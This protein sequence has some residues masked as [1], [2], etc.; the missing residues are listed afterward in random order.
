LFN[1]SGE[2]VGINSQ[3]YS[4]SGGYMGL[5]FAIPIDMA[6][7]VSQQL[8]E[9]G[10]VTRGKIGVGIRGVD[11]DLA[12]AFG[13]DRPRGALVDEVFE[14]DPA[15]KAGVRPG[16]IVLS[17]DGKPVE[18]NTALPALISSIRPGN[19]TELELWS[20]RKL[21]KVTVQV[22]ELKEQDE[23]AREVQGRGGSNQ[24]EPAALGLYLRQLTPEQRQESGTQ[25]SLIV[26][27]VDGP[28]A[29][30]GVRPGDIIIGV[31]GTQVRTLAE[32]QAAIKRS[33]DVVPLRIQ[34][35]ER[36]VFLAVR[37]E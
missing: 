14:G 28:A 32:L 8:M 30:A 2:V 22:V 27:D 1:L 12:E 5:S 24:A 37:K 21:K 13:L 6:T 16:D 35:G 17:V 7:D 9:T 36:Q 25:G 19:T 29:A 20:D 4:Q 26:E 33:G 34:R 11:A 31:G 23:P 3:I 18:S 15:E 10:H